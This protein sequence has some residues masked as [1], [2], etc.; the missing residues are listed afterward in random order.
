M[1]ATGFMNSGDPMPV[2]VVSDQDFPHRLSVSGIYELPFGRGRKFLSD[3][4]PVAR[5]IISGWQ[6]QGIFAGQSGQALGFGNA[7]FTG[8]LKNITLPKDQRK[9]ERWFNVDAG[10]ERDSRQA[11][12]Y[13]TRVMSFRF[14]DIRGDGINT[15]DLSAIK[16]T[17]INEKMKLQFRAEFLNAWN[18]VLFSNPNVDPYSTAF[19]SITS[20]KGYPR[21]IQLGLKLIY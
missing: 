4:N 17:R 18:H 21:R 1:E 14:N 20:E 11:L 9:P 19:G 6:V 13:A 16:D 12:S 3:T 7:I 5:A 8:N 2:E 15:W 10:F